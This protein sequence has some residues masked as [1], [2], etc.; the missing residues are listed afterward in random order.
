MPFL[1]EL[2]SIVGPAHAREIDGRLV[3]SPASAEEIAD[4]LRLCSEAALS[5]TPTGGGTKTEW[6]NPTQNGLHLRTHR[7]AGIREHVWQDLTATVGAGTTWLDMQQALRAH[8]QQ[9]ALDAAMP[10]R[11]T[12]GG[13]VAVND[14]GAL[15]VRYGSLR[16][17]VIGMTIV[18][19]DGTV[20]RS[21]GKVVKNVAG[22]DLPKLLIGS[23]GTL[24]IITAVNFRLHPV[25]ADT[26]SW[27]VFGSSAALGELMQ[28]LRELASSLHSLQLR[29]VG[30]EVALDVRFA[31]APT[32]LDVEAKRLKGLCGGLRVEDAREDVWGW[33]DQM[34]AEQEA[35]VLKITCLPMQIPAVVE[36]FAQS[37]VQARCV[38]EAVGIITV[39]LRGEPELM[40]LLVDDL[41]ARLRASGGMLVV[42]R[43]PFPDAGPERWGGSPPA[44]AL[45]RELKRQFDPQK[46]LSPGRFV[47]GI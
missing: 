20:A 31:S 6:G 33:R 23:F 10:A 22:Y 1:S 27:T 15:R 28:R 13:I 41:R 9:V 11:S 45:M 18:L 2:Q 39:Q 26:Q 21:G 42:L 16:D 38:A 5:V 30:H 19:A 35:A 34:F 4:V 40:K 47:G 37:A 44:I 29:S 17:L 12:V 7:L 32:A 24:G 14:S 46:L 43:W 25:E 3:A 8:G 36:G